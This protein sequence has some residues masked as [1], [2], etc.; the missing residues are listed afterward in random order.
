LTLEEFV[1]NHNG[2]IDDDHYINTGEIDVDPSLESK[3]IRLLK[4]KNSSKKKIRESVDWRSSMNDIRDQN[5]N[6]YACGSC[7]AFTAVSVLEFDFYK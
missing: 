4:L 3:K 1:K 5:Y 6:G 7:W 2:E